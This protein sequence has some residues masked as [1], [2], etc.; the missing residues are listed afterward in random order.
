MSDQLK[1]ESAELIRD[2]R[3]SIEKGGELVKEQAPDIVQEIISLGLWFNFTIGTAALIVFIVCANFLIWA[4]KVGREE[5][6]DNSP[7]VGVAFASFV[8]CVLSCVAAVAHLSTALK[9]YLAPKVYVL[10]YL[11]G[12]L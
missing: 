10:K 12:L 7:P 9:V 4:I 8:T 3:E 11:A 1:Q 6:W 2:L 5:N